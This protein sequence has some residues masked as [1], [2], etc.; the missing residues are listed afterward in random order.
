MSLK[1]VEGPFVKFAYGRSFYFLS[2]RFFLCPFFHNV[3][4]PAECLEE[5]MIYDDKSL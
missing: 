4:Q 1:W 2:P 5:A 3:R